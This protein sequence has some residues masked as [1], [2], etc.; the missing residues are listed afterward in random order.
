MLRSSN[1]RPTQPA[2]SAPRPQVTTGTSLAQVRLNHLHLHVAD[3][4]K[5]RAFY[6]RWFGFEQHT[7]HGP[8]LFLR[9]EGGLDLALAPAAEAEPMPPWFHFGFRLD[10]VEDVQTLHAEMS[11][12]G[13]DIQ[14]PFENWGDFAVFRCLDEDDYVIEV[15][16]E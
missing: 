10:S 5:A 13:V 8:V 12:S 3:V 4:G 14:Q 2:S 7:M 15:Y 9:D 11:D 16:W 6:E 1:R